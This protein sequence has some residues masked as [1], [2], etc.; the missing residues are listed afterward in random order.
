MSEQTPEAKPLPLP[1]HLVAWHHL[2][3]DAAT[4]RL[5]NR[6]IKAFAG[7]LGLKF[8]VL[9]VSALRVEGERPRST[10]LRCM[11]RHDCVGS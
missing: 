7:A 11:D 5:K 4:T 2:V 10:M 6:R 1:R 9:T 8:M 3:K